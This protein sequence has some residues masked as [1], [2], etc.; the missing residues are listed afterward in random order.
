MYTFGHY[1][2]GF[3]VSVCTILQPIKLHSKII[4]KRKSD[5]VKTAENGH[6]QGVRIFSQMLF[7][8]SISNNPPT[9]SY[10]LFMQI[11]KTV[12]INGRPLSQNQKCLQASLCLSQIATN[13]E[14]ELPY[15]ATSLWAHCRVRLKGS[16]IKIK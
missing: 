15:Y 11:A 10:L 7:A 3:I 12:K 9:H 8:W 5:I 6:F 1:Q 4:P 13:R 16:L 14:D 2:Y